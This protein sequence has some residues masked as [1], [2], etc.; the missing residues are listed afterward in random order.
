MRRFAVAILTLLIV[1]EPS[2]AKM[3][4]DMYSVPC[5][6]LWPAVKDT[7][8]NSGN[9]AI[10]MIDNTEMI[11][12][13]AI[14]TGPGLRIDSAVLNTKGDTCEMQVQPLYEGPFSNDGGDFKKR[15]DKALTELQSSQPAA[16]AK[17]ES[18]A[19]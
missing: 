6:A 2:F 4:K 5:G 17:P 9:Y 11:A 13:F 16:P 1:V 19:K 12:S 15:V 3:H 18:P 14:G 8:R 10:L 7:V